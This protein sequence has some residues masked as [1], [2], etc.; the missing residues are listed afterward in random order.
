M[1]SI[2][3][4]IPFKRSHPDD[5][6]IN[7]LN[8]KNASIGKS[9]PS[10]KK[11]RKKMKLMK[12][13]SAAAAAAAALS[14]MKTSISHTQNNSLIQNNRRRQQTKKSKKRTNSSSLAVN[15]A[16]ESLEEYRNQHNIKEKKYPGTNYVCLL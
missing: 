7:N 6:D 3:A 16:T 1:K 9:R 13:A 15:C 4:N 10:N 11:R 2:N 12:K 5:F 8:W 14:D